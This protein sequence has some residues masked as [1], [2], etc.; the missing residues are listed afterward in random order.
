MHLCNG[1][2][3]RVRSTS[4]GLY[5]TASVIEGA[6]AHQWQPF[7]VVNR[8]MEVRWLLDL[9]RTHWL[10]LTMGYNGMSSDGG[11][12]HEQLHIDACRLWN[13]DRKRN[14]NSIRVRRFAVESLRKAKR[15]SN[16]CDLNGGSRGVVGGRSWN[17]PTW[18]DD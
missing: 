17:E 14:H 8:E 6:R 3:A 15:A 1:A 12:A 2:E 4:F 11:C 9:S 10:K 16:D 13:G 18:R 5:D 7:H